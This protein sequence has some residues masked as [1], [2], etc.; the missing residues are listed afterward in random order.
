MWYE[1]T[2]LQMDSETKEYQVA[3]D[4]EDDVSSFPL[5]DDIASGDLIITTSA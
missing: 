1:G 5:L 4:G 3:Y 2:V